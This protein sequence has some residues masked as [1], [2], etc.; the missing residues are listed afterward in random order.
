MH[1]ISFKQ[2]TT[3]AEM[4]GAFTV[5]RAV[6]I[7]EQ[8][9]AEEEEYDGLDDKSLQF[10]A[11]SSRKVIGTARVRFLSPEHAKIERMAV[12]KQ[13]RRQGIGIHIL[14]YIEAAL[15]TRL[16]TEA[17]LHA[18]MVAVP[19][20]KACGFTTVGDTFYEAGIEH[21][22][23]QKRLATPEETPVKKN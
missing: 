10:I 5:R 9:I 19:F 23:M 20:Y 7:I 18:Q 8:N 22:K 15:R 4:S 6:F 2:V 21:I 3:R 16:V 13:Y 12:L 17:I 14:N 1:D 11:R